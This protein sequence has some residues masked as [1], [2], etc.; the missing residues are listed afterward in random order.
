MEKNSPVKNYR[1]ENLAHA[2][3]SAG[4]SSESRPQL[5]GQDQ[6]NN[7]ILKQLFQ[8]SD[9]LASIEQRDQKVKNHLI[10]VR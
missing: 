2:G 3:Q 6:I 5:I 4:G 8:L 1:T 9:M 7:E 10:R